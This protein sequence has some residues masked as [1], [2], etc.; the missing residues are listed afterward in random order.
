MYE[1][2]IEK[3]EQHK[4]AH[5]VVLNGNPS[6]VLLSPYNVKITFSD[7][8]YATFGAGSSGLFHNLSTYGSVQKGHTVEIGGYCEFSDNVEIICGGEHPNDQILNCSFSS[9]PDQM[10]KLRQK[11]VAIEDNTSKG[12][13]TIGSN[14]T[15]SSGAKIL[16]GVSIGHGAVI[17]A[18]AIVTK[19]IP[20]FAVAV[21]NPANVVKY[22]FDEET[23]KDL[24]HIR[25]WDFK[26]DYLFEHFEKLQ[27]CDKSNIRNRYKKTAQSEYNNPNNFIVFKTGGE[28]NPK[29]LQFSGAEVGGNFIAA[30]DLPEEFKFFISQFGLANKPIY[31]IKDI[32]KFSGM[33]G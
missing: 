26:Q 10:A 20:P 5:K 4:I 18:G 3:I 8:G 9:Q 32:F 1:N 13:I 16:S 21:G 11:K 22:R 31:L 24:L 7:D 6:K 15:I 28:A 2:I 29:G 17:G 19:D 27:Q 12:K 33:E 30:K 25:W 23:I 14:V